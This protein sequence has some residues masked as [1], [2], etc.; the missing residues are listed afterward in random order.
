MNKDKM[1]TKVFLILLLVSRTL[2]Y[3]V[4]N[5]SETNSIKTVSIS[6]GTHLPDGAVYFGGDRYDESEYFVDENGV[7]RGCVCLKKQCVQKC[8]PFGFEYSI[9]KKTCV[10]TTAVFDPPVWDDYN[11]LEGWKVT[12]NFHFVFGKIM[13]NVNQS[14]LRVTKATDSL[15]L[16]MVRNYNI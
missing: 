4:C 14:R 7:E 10:N 11:M 13:C 9:D 15:H 12:D 5:D 1:I 2:E 8:C 16:R 6:D 3:Q